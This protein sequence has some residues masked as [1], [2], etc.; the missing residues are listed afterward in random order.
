MTDTGDRLMTL[1]HNT[2]ARQARLAQAVGAAATPG[3]LLNQRR[4]RNDPNGLFS[5]PA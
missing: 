1:I 4:L 2:G 5:A 3:S